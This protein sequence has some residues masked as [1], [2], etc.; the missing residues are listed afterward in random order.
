MSSKR[1]NDFPAVSIGRT[2]GARLQQQ[3]SAAHEA[4]PLLSPGRNSPTPS[5]QG[6]IG[7]TG[8]GSGATLIVN[9]GPKYVPYTPRQRVTATA[10]TTGMTVHPPSPQQHQG[11]ATSKLQLMHLKAAA[12][13]LGVDSGT[14]GW[15]ILEKLVVDIE[16][17]E[18]WTEVWNVITTGKVCYNFYQAFYQLKFCEYR[19]RCCCP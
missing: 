17:S 7:A 2:S 3:A 8:S 1:D 10:A 15:S 6:S 5:E 11:D 4:H 12:Q 13:G 16:I 9:G 18:E 14:L 19:R